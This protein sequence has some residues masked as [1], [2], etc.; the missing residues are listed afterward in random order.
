MQSSIRVGSFTLGHEEI[1][2]LSRKFEAL[3][4]NA[5][6]LAVLAS[7]PVACVLSIHIARLT[8]RELI[9]IPSGYTADRLGDKL[10]DRNVDLLITGFDPNQEKLLFERSTFDRQEPASGGILI[11]TSGTSGIP[12]LAK[13]TWET[14]SASS[15][16]VPDRLYGAKWYLAYEPASYAGLQVFFSAMSSHGNVIIPEQ[17]DISDQIKLIVETSP[18]IISAT[19]TWWRL[20][21]AGWP[22]GTRPRSLKQA[23]LGGEVV[24]QNDLDA[25]GQFF[26]PDQLTHIY[27]STEVGTAIV[28]S[29]RKAGFPAEWLDENR[30]VRMKIE[31]G[32]L[33][34]RSDHRMLGY[35]HDPVTSSTSGWVDTHDMIDIKG[36]RCF[37]LGR[38]DG[39]INVGGRKVRPEEIESAIIRL[40]GIND[41]LVYAKSNPVTGSVLAA[42]VAVKA[43]LDWHISSI[44]AAL[45]EQLPACK[46]PS[47]IRLVDKI[48]ISSNDKKLRR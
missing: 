26:D 22:N 17:R 30:L 9:V 41:S 10:A 16:F 3:F 18:E 42:D 37:L 6:T 11:F 4:R 2:H 14:I 15:N 27:A 39:L 19:P 45:A 31:D 29:D 13:H 33:H 38:A 20:V 32:I 5:G 24:S 35:V 7:S 47:Y 40:K 48:S 23:T 12:K 43:G 46:V 34:I 28:V 21:M 44:K 25:V 1:A 8:K 36:D